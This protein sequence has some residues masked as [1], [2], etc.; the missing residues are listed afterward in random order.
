MNHLQVRP[1]IWCTG[2][3]IAEKV[4]KTQIINKR[5]QWGPNL[6]YVSAFSCPTHCTT[7]L[8]LFWSN[9]QN[10]YNLSRQYIFAKFG[11]LFR[12]NQRRSV[13]TVRGFVMVAT[14]YPIHLFSF[15]I[16]TMTELNF[17]GESILNQFLDDR[18]TVGLKFSC[19]FFEVHR[20]FRLLEKKMVFQSYYICNKWLFLP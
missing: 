11:T 12:L 7:L 17:F 5:K 8:T 16:F 14:N 4:W 20:I 1:I 9:E 6:G 3:I 18:Q 13:K 15:Q 2:A 19:W 10:E